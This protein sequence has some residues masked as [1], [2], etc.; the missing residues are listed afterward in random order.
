MCLLDESIFVEKRKKKELEEKLVSWYKKEGRSFPWRENGLTPY[1]VLIAEMMLQKTR[2]EMVPKVYSTFL[3][4]YPNIKALQL[5]SL[6]D[7][8]NTLKPLGLYNRRARWMKKI[9]ETL[10]ERY[11]GLVPKDPDALISLPGV[12]M[13][14]VNAILCFSF[15]KPVIPLDVNVARVLGRVTG[16]LFNGDLRKNKELHKLITQLIPE[17][18]VKE[19]NW[20]LMDL[21]AIICTPK[22]PKHKNCPLA[23]ICKY[24]LTHDKGVIL[25]TSS[26][27]DHK[28]PA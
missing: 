27:H 25:S 15:D 8:I 14:I 9:A 22:N 3:K 20:A 1:E 13:Y 12:G 28:F 10:V 2:A 24:A 26:I 6:N 7:I 23:L 18:D 11:E 17:K 19:F 16:S 4:K 21:G 5:A